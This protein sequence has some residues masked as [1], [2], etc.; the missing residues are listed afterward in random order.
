MS[1]GSPGPSASARG[2]VARISGPMVVARGMLGARIYE[3]VRVGKA[4]LLGEIIRL[5]GELA[6][7]QTYEDTS[8]L[9]IG[10]PVAATGEPLLVALGPGLLG[11]VFDGIQR[12]LRALEAASGAFIGRGLT[13]EAL[14]AD[15]L[16]EFSPTVRQG[17]TVEPGDIL[18]EVQETPSLIHRILVPPGS[19]VT[20]EYSRPPPVSV[21]QLAPLAAVL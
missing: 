14:P 13:A 16:W 9:Q 2:A 5:D 19:G 12:P 17:Q 7:I 3:V 10:D 6:S 1:D 4:G 18:G 8:S 21:K 20:H 15:R 11:G